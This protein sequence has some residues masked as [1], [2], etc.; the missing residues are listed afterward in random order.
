VIIT[1]RQ[2]IPVSIA[3]LFYDD[4][5]VP[6]SVVTIFLDDRRLMISVAIPVVSDR[7]ANGSNPDAN[8]FR[9]DGQ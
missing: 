4:R 9:S 1:V 6:I 8:F 5:F 2:S 3:V 7:H